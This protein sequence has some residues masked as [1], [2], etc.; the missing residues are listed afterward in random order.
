M[1]RRMTAPAP[2]LWRNR[3]FMLLLSGETASTFLA[4][5]LHVA[6]PAIAVTTLLA[7]DFQ[8]GLLGASES[9]AFLFLTLP[10]GA[11]VDRLS[12]R[13][14]M[15]AAN[16]VR[17]CLVALIPIVWAF[18][19]LSIPWLLWIVFG[20]GVCRVFFDV[21]YMS[22]LPTLVSRAELTN[23]NSRL[24]ATFEV[25]NA[26]G[27]SVA[28]PLV[29][30]FSAPVAP[31]LSVGGFLASA[32]TTWR[33]RE[34]VVPRT[35]TKRDLGGEIREGLDFVR[36]HP[37]ISRVVYS[38]MLS[39]LFGGLTFTMFPVLILRQFAFGTTGLG[40]LMTI[41]SLGAL[42]GALAGPV[43][44][45]RLGDG[46]AI[47][48]AALIEGVAGFGVP[49]SLLVPHAWAFATLAASN[50]VMLMGIVAFNIAQ[51]SLRQRVCPERLLGR[52]NATIRF[53][54]WGVN[55]IASLLSGTIAALI[56][57]QNLFWIGATGAMLAIL[58][59]VFSPL[60][61]LKKVDSYDESAATA[62]ALSEVPPPVL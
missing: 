59:L 5:F 39:N 27:P 47:P 33:I 48:I 1:I 15:I 22:I 52:M 46:H 60:W 55:P 38:A 29:G 7:S 44:V 51:V 8:V 21:A 41:G 42:T 3:S 36:H 17:A 45:R 13:R 16:L 37:L 34:P 4:A 26:A 18:G 14:V 57:L 50:F 54:V 2:S 56:G 11:W 32:F 25:A 53:A 35:V 28:G 19:V 61:G 24:Q 12:R 20:L 6:L 10:A 58:I 40:F 62:E 23:A 9:V 31:L 30:A 43:F 49:A